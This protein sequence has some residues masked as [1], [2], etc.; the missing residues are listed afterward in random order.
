MPL[1]AK[2]TTHHDTA[3]LFAL[4]V[5]QYSP[6]AFRSHNHLFL[7]CQFRKKMWMQIISW[8]NE[9]NITIIE[10]KD[11]KTMLGYMNESP[12]WTFLNHILAIGKQRTYSS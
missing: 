2:A 10:L 6:S 1:T 7:Q 11:S 4:T 5:R 12:H 8:L 3:A 9:F